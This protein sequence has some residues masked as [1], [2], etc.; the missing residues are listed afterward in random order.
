MQ[1]TFY[2]HHE[3]K[4]IIVQSSI[5]SSTSSIQNLKSSS[6]TSESSSTDTTS[7]SS[8][9]KV[10]NT[11]SLESTSSSSKSSSHSPISVATVFSV[12][13][14]AALPGIPSMASSTSYGQGYTPS[15]APTPTQNP[16]ASLPTVAYTGQPIL[17][18]TCT[19][20][21]YTAI[22]LPDGSYL[23]A[24]IVGCNENHP[25]C[26][27]SLAAGTV[28]PT[29]TYLSMTDAA[30]VTALAASPLTICPGDY[31]STSSVCCPV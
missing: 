31:T 23:A 5:T 4:L 18:G 9:T 16:I 8:D 25:Q 6:T 21:Q 10:S 1:Y 19:I 17:V 12:D 20:P 3:C 29:A 26:C 14:T 30:I 11:Q 2:T 24:P 28:T 27:P 13:P 7:S 15:T 22:L